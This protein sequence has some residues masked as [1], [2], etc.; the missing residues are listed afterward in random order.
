MLKIAPVSLP[1]SPW[2]FLKFH[3]NPEIIEGINSTGKLEETVDKKL[4]TIIENFKK[5]NK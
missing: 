4:T 5:T 3:E 2:T 1:A